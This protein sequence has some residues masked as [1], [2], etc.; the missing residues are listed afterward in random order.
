M[1]TAPSAANNA[2][3]PGSLPFTPRDENAQLADAD[4]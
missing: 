4:A 3:A 1:H 2:K